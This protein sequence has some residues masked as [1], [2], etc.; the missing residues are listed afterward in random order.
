VDLSTGDEADYSSKKGVWGFSIVARAREWNRAYTTT[1]QLKQSKEAEEEGEKEK[2]SGNGETSTAKEDPLRKA[3][4]GDRACI[5]LP[6]IARQRGSAW[7]FQSSSHS[8][9]AALSG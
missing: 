5:L 2:L 6:Y 4:L 1:S 8:R 7:V 3:Q 9:W